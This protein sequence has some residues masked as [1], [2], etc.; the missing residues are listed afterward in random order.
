MSPIQA[1]FVGT[2]GSETGEAWIGLI[3]TVSN[4]FVIVFR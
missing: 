2:L 3:A 1:Y 4:I